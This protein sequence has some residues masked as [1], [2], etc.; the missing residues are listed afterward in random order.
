M[1]MSVVENRLLSGR[2]FDAHDDFLS[3]GLMALV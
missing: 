2:E 3:G 1:L